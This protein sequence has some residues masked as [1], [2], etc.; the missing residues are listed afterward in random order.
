MNGESY[1]APFYGRKR[2]RVTST[3]RYAAPAAETIWSR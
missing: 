1:R 3:D 2:G